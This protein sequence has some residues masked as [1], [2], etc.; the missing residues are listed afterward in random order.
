MPHTPP[1]EGIFSK[2]CILG[3]ETPPWDDSK[4]K[5]ICTL[6]IWL[7]ECDRDCLFSCPLFHLSLTF[8]CTRLP[9]I[10]ANSQLGVAV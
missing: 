10:K 2:A 3:V 9:R 8:V 1:Q 5:S 7:Q 6:L 4:G